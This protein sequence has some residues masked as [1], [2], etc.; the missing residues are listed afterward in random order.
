MN[1]LG[2]HDSE[3]GNVVKMRN[4]EDMVMN[5]PLLLLLLILSFH[6]DKEIH[7]RAIDPFHPPFLFS[8]S[9]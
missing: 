2:Y 8:P 4:Y 7:H 1:L 3:A 6:K 9:M 5:D